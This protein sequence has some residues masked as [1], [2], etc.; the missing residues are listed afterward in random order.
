MKQFVCEQR[1]CL[2]PEHEVG[3]D[4]PIGVTVDVLCSTCGHPLFVVDLPAPADPTG[5]I[6]PVD[7]V[8]S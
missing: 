4:M 3:D 1:G 6:D 2:Q 7:P 8:E 5:P